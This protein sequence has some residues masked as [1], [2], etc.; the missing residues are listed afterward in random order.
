MAMRGVLWSRLQSAA[1]H[2]A[3]RVLLILLRL[4]G[5]GFVEHAHREAP[6]ADP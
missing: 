5:A 6:W 1:W 3:F 4:C 2:A